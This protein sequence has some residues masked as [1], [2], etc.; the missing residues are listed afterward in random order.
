MA[1]TVNFFRLGSVSDRLP[2]D[3]LRQK[4]FAATASVR[5]SPKE[6]EVLSVARIPKVKRYYHMNP[7]H[8]HHDV[9]Y[10]NDKLISTITELNST[11]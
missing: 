10:R 1:A 6:T 2:L 5:I 11:N 3:G 8:E 9:N 4:V 7:T